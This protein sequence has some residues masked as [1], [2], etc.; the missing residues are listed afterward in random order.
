MHEE[1]PWKNTSIC[2]NTSTQNAFIS[3][4]IS[5][6]CCFSKY[7]NLTVV[8]GTNLCLKV[9]TRRRIANGKLE[10]AALDFFVVCMKMLPFVDKMEIDDINKLARFT[11]DRVIESDHCPVFLHLNMT[12]PQKS[13]ER[14]EIYNLRNPACI[15][16]FKTE[17]SK[18]VKFSECFKKPK[19]KNI[20]QQVAGWKKNLGLIHQKN[21]SRR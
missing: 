12:L 20:D 18:N 8:N 7:S 6:S 14:V 13:A 4:N 2:A 19:D 3:L 9:I 16:L 21:V 17:T 5:N 1:H 11:K 10:E 15:D